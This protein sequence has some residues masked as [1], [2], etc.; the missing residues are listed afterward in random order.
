MLICVYGDAIMF[1]QSHRNFERVNN[2]ERSHLVLECLGYL[3]SV[4]YFVLKIIYYLPTR[5]SVDFLY[6][7]NKTETA[8]EYEKKLYSLNTTTLAH[9]FIEED[10]EKREKMSLRCI[11][12]NF[13]V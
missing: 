5:W 2:G 12:D 9:L 6:L 10:P 7:I 4:S 1:V 13:S 8:K 11:M 3:G